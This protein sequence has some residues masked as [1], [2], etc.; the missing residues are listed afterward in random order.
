MID[1]SEARQRWTALMLQDQDNNM[2]R[3]V[4]EDCDSDCWGNIWVAHDDEPLSSIHD[5]CAAGR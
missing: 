4:D 3:P 5:L 1:L 2:R